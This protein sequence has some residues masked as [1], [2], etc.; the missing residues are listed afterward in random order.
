MPSFMICYKMVTFLLTL[1]FVD[2]KMTKK[3]CTNVNSISVAACVNSRAYT[4]STSASCSLK[5]ALARL[6]RS[7]VTA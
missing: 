7:W 5:A 1:M 2:I 4:C 6:V 3:S